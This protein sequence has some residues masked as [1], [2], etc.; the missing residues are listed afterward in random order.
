MRWGG[1]YKKLERCKVGRKVTSRNELKNLLNKILNID[2]I[3]K[4]L[5]L[6]VDLFLVDH[7]SK[8]MVHFS[9]FIK[10]EQSKE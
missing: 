4:L 10:G 9:P 8:H 6:M 5:D 7:E 2:E 1:F 3:N